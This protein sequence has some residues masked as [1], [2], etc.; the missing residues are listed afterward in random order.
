MPTVFVDHYNLLGISPVASAEEVQRAFRK[1]A[2]IHHPDKKGGDPLRFHSIY[3]AYR[4]LSQESTRRRF[5]EVFFRHRL[6]QAGLN[7]TNQ[8]TKKVF[9]VGAERFVYPTSV[10]SLAKRGLLRKKFRSRDRRRYLRIDYDLELPLLEREMPGPLRIYVPV[11]ARILCPDCLGSDLDCYACNGK[12]SY[13]ASRTVRLDL[14]G[15]LSEGQILQLDLTGL[16]P[17][18]P[19]SYFKKKTIRI[20][21]TCIRT[22]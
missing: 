8:I 17:D 9:R 22:K 12:G 5:D 20:K 14:E 2:K 21:I 7:S 19:L 18:G 13:K 11:V 6:K 4:I 3:T 1:L 10:A 15:G 16:R